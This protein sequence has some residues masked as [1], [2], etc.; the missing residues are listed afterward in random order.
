MALFG[1]LR[2]GLTQSDEERLAQEVRGWADTVPGSVR[3]AG[4]PS[5][6]PVTVAGVVRRI[7]VIPA[8]GGESLEALVSDGTGE[9][10][11]VWM[12]RRVIQGLNLGTRVI[13]R[14]VIGDSRAGRRIVNPTF[15]FAA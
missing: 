15:E 9:I 12:G 1:K 7:T 6:E 10:T 11:V 14:G 4:C 8:Q 3:L 5:R 2:K 13:L